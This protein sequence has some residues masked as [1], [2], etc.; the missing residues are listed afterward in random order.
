[1]PDVFP[2]EFPAVLEAIVVV[3]GLDLVVYGL[4][5]KG[6]GGPRYGLWM[7]MSSNS[8]S[9]ANRRRGGSRR[10]SDLPRGMG[11]LCDW[12]GEVYTRLKS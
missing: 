7:G 5:G 1:M 9:S 2:E 4:P 10:V 6:V 12:V 8:R 3:L 11:I